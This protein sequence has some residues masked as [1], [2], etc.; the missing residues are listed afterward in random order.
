MERLLRQATGLLALSFFFSAVLNY[1]VASAFIKTEPSVDA[2]QFN[3][4]VGAMTGWSYLIIAVPSMILLFGIMYWVVRG[5]KRHS[6]LSFE[7]ALA[8]HL[9]EK[10][11]AG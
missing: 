5:I 7:E 6:G 2:A 3:A 1:I 11:N 8:P 4:E 9:Q 10:S